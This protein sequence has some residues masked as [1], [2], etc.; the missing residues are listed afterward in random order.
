MHVPLQHWCVCFSLMR[1]VRLMQSDLDTTSNL[2]YATTHSL[3]AVL[4]L[5][6]MAITQRMQNPRHHGPITAMCVDKKRTWVLVG[7][8]TGVLTLWDRRFGL[9][10]KSW[11]VGV[12]SVGR[13]VR[14]HQ[15]VLHP[16]K[17]KGKY[18]MVAIEATTGGGRTDL[19]NLVEVWDIEASV[20][21]D[22]FVTR[23]ASDLA[24][25]KPVTMTGVDANNTAAEAIA[26]LVRQH[27]MASTSSVA[28]AVSDDGVVKPSTAPDV[29]ALV[30]GTEFGGHQHRGELFDS[31]LDS[32]AGPSQRSGVRGF[33]ITG[34]EDCKIRYWGMGRP[35]RSCVLNG[36]E[37]ETDKPAYRCACFY[38]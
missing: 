30:V 18:V 35:E 1:A 4:D 14:I 38:S 3:I 34:S 31:G 20:L 29:R 32:G 13:S 36:L 7:T 15:C 19:T 17:G 6:T 22:T 21:V 26:S 27:Q 8:S 24:P 16:T 23:M 12:A 25:V 10:L 5:R 2:V 33:M 28:G 11:H 9:L 37:T